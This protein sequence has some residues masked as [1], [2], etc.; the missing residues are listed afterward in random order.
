M[1]SGRILAGRYAIPAEFRSGGMARVYKAVDLEHDSRY[2]AVKILNQQHDDAAVAIAFERETKSLQR[3]A[4]PNIVELLDAGRDPDGGDRYLVFEWM[5]ESLDSVLRTSPGWEEYF[6]RWGVPILSAVAHAHESAVAHRDLKPA[7]IL[8]DAEQRPR[9]SD[10]GIAKI[11][12]GFNS[13]RTLSDWQTPPYSPPEADDGVHYY[14]RD[15]HAFGVLSLLILTGV[16]PYATELT[17]PY[18]AIETALGRLECPEEITDLLARCVAENWRERPEDAAVGLASLR[19]CLSAHRSGGNEPRLSLYLTMSETVRRY[20]ADER[21]LQAGSDQERELIEELA[22]GAAIARLSQETFADGRST[23]DH[24]LIYAATVRLHVL[25]NSSRGGLHLLACVAMRPSYLERERERACP[26]EFDWRFGPPPEE[27]GERA[28]RELERAVEEH[29]AAERLGGRD[30]AE[31][32]IAR[33][34]RLLVATR[35]LEMDGVASAVY[36]RQRLDGRL[37]EFRCTEEVPTELVGPVVA[38]GVDSAFLRGEVILIEGRRALMR[39]D[40]GDPREAASQGELRTDTGGITT[41]IKRQHRAL[42]SIEQET[43]VG[44]NL[45]ELIV[46]PETARPPQAVTVDE[47]IQEVDEA[48]QEIVERALGSKDVLHVEGPPGTGKTTLITE[49]ILQVLRADPGRRILLSA[50]THA[51]L[52]N[53]LER[54]AARDSDLYLVRGGRP[55]DPR[56]SEG[57]SEFL[58]DHQVKRWKK[59]VERR[60]RKYLATWAKKHHLSERAVE[61]AS[62]LEELAA[63]V[64]ARGE[65]EATLGPLQSELGRMRSERKDGT[66]SVEVLDGLVDAVAELR[67]RQKDLQQEREELVARLAQLR[68]ATK[69]ELRDS[70]PDQL[71]A[72]AF[73][74]LPE[75]TSEIERCQR[76]IA[77]LAEW[78][79]RF[80]RG[81]G[82]NGAA[83]SRA[84]VVASTCV[85]YDGIDGASAIEFDL[86][87]VDEAS[88]ATPPEVLI[89]MTRAKSWVLVGDSRQLPPF[90]REALR[91]PAVLAEYNLSD[92]QVRETLFSR[93]AENLG[94]ESKA[95]LTLQHRMVAPISGLISHCF[96]RDKLQAADV[97]VRRDVAAALPAP[98]TW[99]ST[100]K[101]EHRFERS[102]GTS[103]VN[104]LESQVARLILSVVDLSA[105]RPLRVAVLSGYAPQVGVVD[106]ALSGSRWSQLKVE[107]STIDAYQGR[108]SDLVIYLVTRSNAQGT[109]GFL[110]ER[111]RLNV[112]LSRA[113]EGLVIIGDEDFIDSVPGEN[114]FR[115]VLAYIRAAPESDCTVVEASTP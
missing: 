48:K 70:T 10:F 4:H 3:L 58:L 99:Y 15:V 94:A 23:E 14:Q 69:Y 71:R 5:E 86:C 103:W 11:V 101:I 96:Y 114:P 20:L 59:K 43:A 107:C 65:V 93:W 44:R 78:H 55:D 105:Q 72:K 17:S 102:D 108:E 91:D 24:Y 83:L 90:T 51:A 113:R 46:H 64:E 1:N 53:V 75:R 95:A 62:R 26:L 73:E 36:D 104:H 54:V 112:A 60:G 40:D 38:D 47:W 81:A 30:D 22:D 32:L 27:E 49:L 16:D 97:N 57:A 100:S 18:D 87:I 79:A 84:Q 63:V 76:M 9:I 88:Q 45:K 80:G 28:I 31:S 67:T 34:R 21:D 25:V 74:V 37:V 89:P 35:A 82:F 77:L 92:R 61:T 98:V 110:R 42:D 56:V 50:K 19:R 106:R 13:G 85:G 29:A 66:T 109:L 2:V 33:W 111:P 115:P 7:N 52:D 41:A 68:A 12:T 8:V 39:I 6:R